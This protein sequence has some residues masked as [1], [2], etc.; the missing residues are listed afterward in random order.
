MKIQLR[1]ILGNL[2]I[3]HLYNKDLLLHCI[4]VYDRNARR[5]RIEIVNKENSSNMRYFNITEYKK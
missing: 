1:L 5:E 4:V 3:V 2:N